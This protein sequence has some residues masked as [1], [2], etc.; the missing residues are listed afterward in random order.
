MK[1]SAEVQNLYRHLKLVIVDE[2]HALL[3][4][5]RGIQLQSLL[6]RLFHLTGHR[7]RHIGL[8]ATIGDVRVAQQF[9]NPDQPDAVQVIRQDDDGRELQLKIS[10]YLHER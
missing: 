3:D 2:V 10:A 1:R 4:E 5:E 7:P 8:S 9:L 6:S